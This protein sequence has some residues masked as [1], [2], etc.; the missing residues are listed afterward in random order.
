M[1]LSNG[2]LL[3]DEER[4]GLATMRAELAAA[5]SDAEKRLALAGALHV[6]KAG[7]PSLALIGPEGVALAALVD[8]VMAKLGIE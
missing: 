2:I 8:L 7:A 5:T 1:D 3:T 6:V 4:S